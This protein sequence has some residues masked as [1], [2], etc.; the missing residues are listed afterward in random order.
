MSDLHLLDIDGTL[1]D[2]NPVHLEAYKAAYRK[3][4]DKE[5][6]D[7]E[8]L[9]TFGMPERQQHETVF[10]N[11]RWEDQGRIDRVITE[12]E[13]GLWKALCSTTASPLP[14]V[15][16]YLRELE[17]R[18]DHLGI[19][20]GNTEKNG[21]ES[22]IKAGLLGHF[23]VFGFGDNAKTRNEIVAR[24]LSQAKTKAYQPRKIVVV[25]DS[26]SDVRCG[27]HINALTVAVTTGPHKREKLEA[28][29]PDLLLDSLE[30]YKDIF[31][32]LED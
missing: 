4:L 21:R 1:L 25:G 31:R 5:V 11:H 9:A 32:A 8:L 2:L 3:V 15:T 10:T 12:Y 20:T 30:Q 23:S 13:A 26:P 22:L 24:A 14:G 19:V 7:A 17:R 29:Q 18:Q 27:K 28:E 6:S 16:D